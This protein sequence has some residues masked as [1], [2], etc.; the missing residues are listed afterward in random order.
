MINDQRPTGCITIS[1]VDDRID[2]CCYLLSA[3]FS[4]IISMPTSNAM[5]AWRN[6]LERI[7]DSIFPGT[8]QRPAYRERYRNFCKTPFLHF[9]PETF[10]RAHS[11][12]TYL[13]ALAAWL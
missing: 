3:A 4:G 10:M 5:P 2:G 7:H 6:V 12:S 13:G 1:F 11:D 8:L 9:R